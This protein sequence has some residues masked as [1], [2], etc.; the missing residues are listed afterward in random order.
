MTLIIWLFFL[1]VAYM[2]GSLSSA[3]IICQ[4]LGYP[5]PRTEGSNNPGATNVLRIAGKKVA[6]LVLVG[7]VLKG[8]IPVILATFLGIKGFELG[9]IALAAVVGHMYPVFFQFKGGKGVATALGVLFGLSLMLTF[10]IAIVWFSAVMFTRYVSLGAI[11][12]AIAAPLLTFLTGQSYYF[13]PITIISLLIIWR[14]YDNIM[15]LKE[16]TEGKTYFK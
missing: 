10:L 14:H 11:C 2:M 5:D 4:L 9:F 15:R 7:D 12:S 3:I 16:G 1:V 6:A 8:F 13:I